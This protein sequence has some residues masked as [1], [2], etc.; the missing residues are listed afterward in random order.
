MRSRS[1]IIVHRRAKEEIY[2]KIMRREQGVMPG[3]TGR[4]FEGIGAASPRGATLTVSAAITRSS[5]SSTLDKFCTT[6]LHYHCEL[7]EL[8]ETSGVSDPDLQAALS[9]GYQSEDVAAFVPTVGIITDDEV[10][11]LDLGSLALSST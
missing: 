3:D 4:L 10:I 11:C 8:E 7:L 9:Q 5:D 1:G 2:G 6:L